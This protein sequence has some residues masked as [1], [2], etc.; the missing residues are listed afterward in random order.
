MMAASRDPRHYPQTSLVTTGTHDTETL[1][2][3]WETTNDWEREMACRTWPE[4][5]TF[6]PPPK[7]WSFELHEALLRAALN[8]QSVTCIFPWQDVFGEAER[9]NTPG[10]MGDHNWAYRMKPEVQQLATDEALQRTANWLTRLSHEGR[11][12]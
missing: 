4:L 8:A 7:E 5:T 3:W 12:A 11:R 2:G 1:R 10:T 6:A 9:T